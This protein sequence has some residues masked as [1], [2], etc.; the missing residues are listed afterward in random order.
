MMQTISGVPYVLV[1]P[2]RSVLYPSSMYTSSKISKALPKPEEGSL[3]FVVVD[4]SHINT[5]D[6]TTAVVSCLTCPYNFYVRF[7]CQELPQ[8][9]LVDSLLSVSATFCII[10]SSLS[11]KVEVLDK[12]VFLNLGLGM[13]G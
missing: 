9:A 4:G 12:C 5:A 3:Q 2:D 6:Y 10:A 7:C 11:L 8:V 13:P 1:S